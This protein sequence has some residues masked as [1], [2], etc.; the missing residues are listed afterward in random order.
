MFCHLW[1]YLNV[2]IG[3]ANM[4]NNYLNSEQRMLNPIFILRSVVYTNFYQKYGK[5]IDLHTQILGSQNSDL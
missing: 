2:L 3:P 4:I 5:C 1:M